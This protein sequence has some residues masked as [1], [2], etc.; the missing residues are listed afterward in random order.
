MGIYV[1]EFR[2]GD[3]LE[4]FLLLIESLD[5]TDSVFTEV[6]IIPVA[7]RKLKTVV[8]LFTSKLAW[9][10]QIRKLNAA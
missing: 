1:A 3:G 6:F 9:C 7:K 5:T 10:G 8:M 4:R 2:K